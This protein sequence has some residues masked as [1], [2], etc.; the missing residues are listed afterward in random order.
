MDGQ[1]IMIMISQQWHNK[2]ISK[3]Q[4]RYF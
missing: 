1:E 3:T 2:V 4:Q